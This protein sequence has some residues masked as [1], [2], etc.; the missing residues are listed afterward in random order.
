[1][2]W[3]SVDLDALPSRGTDKP[4]HLSAHYC[5]ATP[6]YENAFHLTGV[7]S[8]TLSLLS[9][10]AEIAY[11]ASVVQPS[12]FAEQVNELGFTAQVIETESITANSLEH[13]SKTIEVTVSY[14]FQV[15]LIANREKL[16]LFWAYQGG[17]NSALY[18]FSHRMLFIAIILA[19]AL[20]FY[21]LDVFASYGTFGFGWHLPCQIVFILFYFFHS[22]LAVLREFSLSFIIII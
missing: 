17:V 14:C 20:P 3:N 15:V 21:A 8:A 9:T 18:A 6:W 19:V 22:V 4:F 11:D 1:M 12:I 10:K 7:K 2:K 13:F 16:G 5:L